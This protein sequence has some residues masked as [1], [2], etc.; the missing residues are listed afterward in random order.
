MMTPV[1][2][3]RCGMGFDQAGRW[4]RERRRFI[5]TPRK[6]GDEDPLAPARGL[7]WGL[8]AGL[9]LWAG[10]IAVGCTLVNLF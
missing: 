2:A 6:F 10:I 7:A 3:V 4:H 1:E 8:L 9:G 5:P